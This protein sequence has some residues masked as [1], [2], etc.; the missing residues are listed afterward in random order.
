[1]RQPPP[2]KKTVSGL[3]PE[4]LELAKPSSS[5]QSAE[6]I[7]PE[8]FELAKPTASKPTPSAV[9]QQPVTVEEG[10]RAF[11]RTLL[12]SLPGA[13][14]AAGIV[15]KV[16]GGDYQKGR[17]AFAAKA[18]EAKQKIGP[19]SRTLANFAG[20]ALPYAI[21]GPVTKIGRALMAGGIGAVRGVSRVGLKAEEAPSI[22]ET[23]KA[24]GTGAVKEAALEQVGNIFGIAGKA[25]TSPK[26]G[27]LLLG[28]KAAR[29]AEAG[30]AYESF[31]ALGD[32][33]RTQALTEVMQTPAVR[34]AFNSV[35]SESTTLRKLSITDARVL[36]AVYKRIGNK[37]WA[38]SA[39]FQELTDTRKAL[40]DA[41]NDAAV[42][43]MTTQ[44]GSN[45]QAIAALLS[46]PYKTPVSAFAR[47][48]GVM[49]A[50]VRGAKGLRTATQ[51]GGASE[52]TVMEYGPTALAEWAKTATPEQK[53][54]AIQGVYAQLKESP[55]RRKLF[56]PSKTLLAAP[57]VLGALGARSTPLQRALRGAV[58]SR[59]SDFFNE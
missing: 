4:F 34:Q 29:A 53:E 1:M 27:A 42:Q 33:P 24:A 30:P 50:T 40:L 14:M 15:Q 31:K 52:K 28:Q 23:A 6:D 57:E 17:Q 21:G 38:K 45:P 20:E 10:Q 56:V 22:T 2:K 43:K 5:V 36:D 37:A 16:Q 12:S 11:T 18:E 35:L 39:N 32:L 13:E 47:G 3:D 49:N 8:F 44:A 55:L 25:M 51:A 19:I 7:D 58:A 26:R 41:I 54:A 9:A 59:S 46:T 48:S